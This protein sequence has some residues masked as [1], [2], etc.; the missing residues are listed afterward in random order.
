[1]TGYQ[2]WLPDVR[3]IGLDFPFDAHSQRDGSGVVADS[4][5][6]ALVAWVCPCPDDDPL[7]AF[8]SIVFYPLV[9]LGVFWIFTPPLTT[10]P[11]LIEIGRRWRE[12]APGYAVWL[13]ILTVLFYL[14]YFYQ[15]ARFVAGPATV[16]A[17]Y[18]GVAIARWIERLAATGLRREAPAP[19][20]APPPAV[21]AER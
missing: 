7:V 18:S 15:G 12:A 17:V 9:L 16:L 20:D 6:G 11:G 8:P 21:L 19:S 3:T 13:T 4:L 2:Y 1:M 14:I 10:V 5:D